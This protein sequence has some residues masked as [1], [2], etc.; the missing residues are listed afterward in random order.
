MSVRRVSPGDTLT[1]A[2]PMRCGFRMEFRAKRE[3]F[4][5]LFIDPETC[6]P[7]WA[8]VLRCHIHDV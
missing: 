7:I 6:G 5:P 2:C 1:Y 4:A 8:H 3:F